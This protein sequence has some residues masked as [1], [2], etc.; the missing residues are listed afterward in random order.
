MSLP[1]MQF[2]LR[3]PSGN[4]LK[5]MVVGPCTWC[6]ASIR[7]PEDVMEHT[8]SCEKAPARLR[9]LTAAGNVL[10]RAV[11]AGQVPE[12]AQI[13]EAGFATVDD[14]FDQLPAKLFKARHLSEAVTRWVRELWRLPEPL[15]HQVV[16]AAQERVAQ[17]LK[18][19]S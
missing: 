10:T 6:E 7:I 2:T 8:E 1:A 15:L 14:L 16:E 12:A 9:R 17:R 5:E 13:A 4:V 18:R 3:D 19:P 11:K